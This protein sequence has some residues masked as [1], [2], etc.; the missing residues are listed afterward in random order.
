MARSPGGPVVAV[1]QASR[2]PRRWRRERGPARASRDAESRCWLQFDPSPELDAAAHRSGEVLGK[3]FDG[4]GARE[5]GRPRTRSSRA[6]RPRRAGYVWW[7]DDRVV[8]EREGGR[9]GRQRGESS[10]PPLC[11]CR[12]ICGGSALGGQLRSLGRPRQVK[13]DALELAISLPRPGPAPCPPS[14]P[15]APRGGPPGAVAPRPCAASSARSRRLTAAARRT[16]HLH[17]GEGENVSVGCMQAAGGGKGSRTW[18]S[19]VAVRVELGALGR[20][21]AAVPSRAVVVRG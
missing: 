21:A 9:A 5:R 11:E 20:S 6:E 1:L 19:V 8:R 18:L 17:M 7:C 15:P 2:L 13:V 10:R 12:R 16:R 14:C 3:G 4:A